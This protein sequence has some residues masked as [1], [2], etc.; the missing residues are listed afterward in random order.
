MTDVGAGCGL[1]GAPLDA[2]DPD[3]FTITAIHPASVD[4]NHVLTAADDEITK[5]A[6]HGLESE[7]LAR[8]TARWA[9]ALFREHDRLASRTLALGAFELLHGRAEL[10]A[11]LPSMVA[12]LGPEHIAA[13]AAR[14]VPESRAVLVLKPKGGDA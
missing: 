9:A 11:E 14:L 4:V 12:T 2:R 5:L 3:T 13:A 10:V 7:E 8:V 6:E 1:L